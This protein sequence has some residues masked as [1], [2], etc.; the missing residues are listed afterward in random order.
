MRQNIKNCL[1]ENLVIA[2]FLVNSFAAILDSKNNCSECLKRVFF[3]FLK[4]FEWQRRNAKNCLNQNLII[5]SFLE[6]AFQVS[7]SSR[8]NIA[9]IW[10]SI[11]ANFW[12]TTL[13]PF[14]GKV[15]Q[16]AQI[17]LNENLVKESFLENGLRL[18]WAKKR[19]F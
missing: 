6:N 15:Q 10:N 17:Y 7:L 12:L 9:G 11:F 16:S 3:S 8:T 13:K 14:S 4:I 19:M 2:I 1:N 5:G 18:P